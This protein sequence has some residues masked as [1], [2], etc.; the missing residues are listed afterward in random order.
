MQVFEVLGVGFFR[1][2]AEDFRFFQFSFWG[3]WVRTLTPQFQSA[4]NTLISTRPVLHC[5]P[6]I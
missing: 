2:R 6:Q 5:N 4:I 3:F 1:F